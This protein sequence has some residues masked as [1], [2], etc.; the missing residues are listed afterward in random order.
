MIFGM[1]PLTSVHVVISLI[2]IVSGLM[3]VYG[4]LAAKRLAVWTAIFLTATVLTSVTG[5]FL[6]FERFL[7]S[8]ALGIISLIVLAIAF[9]SLY[10][11]QLAGFWR[12]AYVVSSVTALYLNVVVLIVQ[13]FL[14]IPLLHA[15]APTQAEPP[16]LVTQLL[17]LAAFAAITIGGV[18]RFRILPT[19]HSSLERTSIA[20]S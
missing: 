2:G 5:F 11:R 4:L 12:P 9:V 13:V 20:R 16:F 8:H 6:P 7:P 3:V 17:A 1:T 15:L 10:V 14:K 19:T 18:I